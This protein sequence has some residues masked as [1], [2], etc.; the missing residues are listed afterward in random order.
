MAKIE[1]VENE[2]PNIEPKRTGYSKNTGGDLN[3]SPEQI[4]DGWALLAKNNKKA[5][6]EAAKLFV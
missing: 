5:F 2:T 3:L 6:C 1:F 4:K